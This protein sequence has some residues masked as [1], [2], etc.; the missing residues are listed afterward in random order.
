MSFQTT[1]TGGSVTFRLPSE[2][3]I[4]GVRLE[5]DFPIEPTDPEFGRAERGWQLELPQPAV[6]R[7][8]YQFTV[9][10]GNG[11]RWQTD[12]TNPR[13]VP[14]PFGDKSEV[15]F[16]G[17][18]SPH[19][20]TGPETG[21][22][23]PVP[24]GRGALTD[25][26]P[27][28]LWTPDGLSPL[29]PAPLLVVHD[30]SDMA[31]RGSLLRWAGSAA[32]TRPF[33][34]ALLDPVT[35]RRDDWYAAAP[36][37]AHHLATVL[38]PALRSKVAVSGTVGLGASLGALA[39]LYAHR[40]HPGLLQGLVLQSGSYFCRELDPQESGYGSFEAICTA[41]TELLEG[42]AA[43]P[44]PVHMTCGLVEENRANNEAMAAA[45]RSQGF[46]LELRLVRDAHTMIGWRDAWSPGL[47]GVLD[48]VAR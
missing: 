7:L 26:V 33:R 43:G 28:T 46:A 8:E 3:G 35:G 41:V 42:P 47:E 37:Y 10:D 15:L 6:D 2:P 1:V 32:R 25:A 22:L 36:D 5:L 39:M 11:T 27:V 12:A 20:L 17:Y 14:N 40:R 4:S 23:Q 21:T 30:G 18:R 48:A 44:C 29:D 19:W 9:R 13:R 34:I 45:L 31:D 16:P 38:L 24:T